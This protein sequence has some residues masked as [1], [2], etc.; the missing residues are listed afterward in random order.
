MRSFPLDPLVLALAFS[1]FASPIQQA[2][3]QQ[4]QLA[5]IESGPQS[6]YL[7]KLHKLPEVSWPMPNKLDK[8]VKWANLFC[9]DGLTLTLWSSLPSQVWIRD[10]FNLNTGPDLH[11]A[12]VQL[13]VIEEHWERKEYHNACFQNLVLFLRKWYVMFFA[14]M[15]VFTCL[16]R[17]DCYNCTDIKRSKSASTLS[18]ACWL[19]QPW[20]AANG[21]V[22][23]KACG[24]WHVACGRQPKSS[25]GPLRLG[26]KE[27][28]LFTRSLSKSLPLETCCARE[29]A[30]LRWRV[31]N[32]KSGLGSYVFHLMSPQLAFSRTV[33]DLL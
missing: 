18:P 27:T 10:I 4:L 7:H 24:M 33:W 6:R 3:L 17:Y 23:V 1:S 16:S 14:S 19:Q 12:S 21:G 9:Q 13:S 26:R 28:F 2:N 15:T 22:V 11:L 30:E 32:A 5:A 8:W 25:E 20:D 29:L 31:L